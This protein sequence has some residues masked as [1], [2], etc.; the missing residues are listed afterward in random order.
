[1]LTLA[2]LLIFL[3]VYIAVWHILRPRG[4][5]VREEWTIEHA[6]AN[7]AQKLAYILVCGLVCALAAYGV[8]GQ[9]HFALLGLLGG[10]FAANWLEKR[11]RKVQEETLRAQYGQVLTS[12]ASA[13]QGNLS[14][15]Q[16]LEDITPSLPNPSRDV[17]VEILSR[18]RTGSNL[19]TA[20]QDVAKIT[21]W[22]DI[23]SL[24]MAFKL[25]DTTGCDLVE[26]LNHLSEAIRERESDRKYVNAVTAEIRT[27]ASVLSVLP[28][29][30]IGMIR[31][32]APGF[33]EPLF[34]TA[35]GNIVIILCFVLVIIGN[36]FV[37]G[38]VSKS[39]GI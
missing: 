28:F 13:M 27:T 10:Y 14:H 25:Y 26:V 37:K 3:A 7:T 8:T 16:G 6:S 36:S 23:A 2:C 19:S 5:S 9:L 24:A 31:V 21:G 4:V 38:M 35:S 22:Q 34:A 15:Y 29:G 11:K 39:V 20:V 18:A 33:A 17:F 32:M 30:I 12:I 1:M